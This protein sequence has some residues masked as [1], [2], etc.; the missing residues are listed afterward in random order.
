MKMATIVSLC[1]YAVSS[2]ADS[3]RVAFHFQKDLPTM[4]GKSKVT[5]IVIQI[6][7]AL[8]LFGIAAIFARS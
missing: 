6:N 4:R 5:L 8:C 3:C 7:I 1:P 2:G